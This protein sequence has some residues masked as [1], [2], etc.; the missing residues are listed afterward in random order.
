MIDFC[1]SQ[2]KLIR[3]TIFPVLEMMR[4]SK[5]FNHFIVLLILVIYSLFL[6]RAISEDYIVGDDEEWNSQANF[7]SWSKKYNFTV[8]DVLGMIFLL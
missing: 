7:L 6:N 2:T 5:F 8:G 4:K 3:K 1:S